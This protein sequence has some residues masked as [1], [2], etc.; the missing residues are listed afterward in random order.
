MTRDEAARIVV[1][2]CSVHRG[3]AGEFLDTLVALGVL[4]LDEPMSA[5]EIYYKTAS[6]YFNSSIEANEFKLVLEEAGLK[7]VEKDK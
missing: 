4:N 3:K 5:L 2:K 6:E 7:I 1:E